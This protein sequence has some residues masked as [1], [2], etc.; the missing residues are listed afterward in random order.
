MI[1]NITAIAAGWAHSVFLRN[2]GIVWACGS[3]LSG[4][5]G[6]G[7]TTN[8]MKP[9]VV[10]GLTG[11][12]A[13]AAGGDH[14]LFLKNDGTVWACGNNSEGQLGDGTTIGKL[15]PVQVDGLT[16]ITAIAG[17][18]RHSLFLKNDGTAWACGENSSGQIGD[19]SVTDRLTPVQVNSLCVETSSTEAHFAENMM[20]T[21]PWPNPTNNELNFTLASPLNGKVKIFIFNALGQ[22]VK[23]EVAGCFEETR[24]IS[25]SLDGLVSGT[26]IL[27]VS[28]NDTHLPASQDK[29]SI[30]RRFVL[31]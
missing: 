21:G 30:F 18:R 24:P 29:H 4:Q 14:S 26:Y 15:I 19:G 6:N 12:T 31:K 8:K 10:F 27:Q 7:T 1:S 25:I 11:I 3:N 13:I 23:S 17:G 28:I 16:G 9:G 22:L 5:L 2:D 20:L